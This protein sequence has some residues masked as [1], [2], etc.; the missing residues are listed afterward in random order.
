MNQI[1]I[2]AVV[3]GVGLFINPVVSFSQG[4]EVPGLNT[5][6]NPCPLSETKWK[7]LMKDNEKIIKQHEGQKLSD[8]SEEKRNEY[9]IALARR[10]VLVYGPA[11]YREYK[12]PVIEEGVYEPLP[13]YGTKERWPYA[14]QPYY[15]V[16]FPYDTSK[17][18]FKSSFI[19]WVVIMKSDACIAQIDFNQ[20]LGLMF[21]SV[22]REMKARER[23]LEDRSKCMTYS[24]Y[25]LTSKWT[26]EI[27]EEIRPEM[28]KY[29]LLP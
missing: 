2:Y 8:L 1:L 11:F 3:L 26:K 29:H 25:S 7:K 21:R 27:F 10:C 17:E 15:V 13:P 6:N 18:L 24:S 16:R 12:E 5:T 9:L 19:A 28:E 22:E 14:E 23:H 4:M 20:D